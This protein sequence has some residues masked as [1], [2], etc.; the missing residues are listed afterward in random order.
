MR[1]RV[2]ILDDLIKLNGNLNSLQ[3]EL[4]QYKWDSEDPLVVVKIED[5]S[6]VL[7]KL[8]NR[9]ITSEIV[10]DWAN[11]IE[12]RDDIDFESN[13]LK[14][15]VHELAN[16]ELY[17]EINSQKIFSFIKTLSKK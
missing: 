2:Q 4:G 10:E 3:K 12:V 15:V 7:N 16:P 9:L 11:T 17:G 1:D 8:D 13:E 14:E 5:L 6:N